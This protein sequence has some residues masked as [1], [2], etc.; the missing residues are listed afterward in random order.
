MSHNQARRQLYW[1]Y[2]TN[3]LNDIIRKLSLISIGHCFQQANSSSRHV[4]FMKISLGLSVWSQLPK[5][6]RCH[7][8]TFIYKPSYFPAFS[9]PWRS[10]RTDHHSVNVPLRATFPTPKSRTYDVISISNC[11]ALLALRQHR[12]K[13]MPFLR[14]TLNHFDR[15]FLFSYFIII[16]IGS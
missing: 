16:F 14:F 10:S 8:T 15:A 13:K 12:L 9:Q 7:L 6:C 1:R 5:P 2:N 4:D 3:K 11:N